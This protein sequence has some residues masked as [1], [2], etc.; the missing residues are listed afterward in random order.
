MIH[1]MTAFASVESTHDFGRLVWELRTVNHRYQESNLR[2]PEDFRPMEPAF[3]EQISA[4]VRRG[5]LDGN[6]KFKPS[7]GFAGSNLKLNVDLANSL[8]AMHED[9]SE[10]SG[11]QATA[12]AMEL[13][14]WPGVVEEQSGDVQPLRDAAVELLQQAMQSLSA[15]R[16]REGAKLQN[17]INERLDGIEQIISDVTGW[18]PEI[19]SQIREK[20]LARIDQLK[21]PLDEGRMEQEVAFLAQKLDVDEELD[22]L[23]MHV[24]ETRR[25]LTLEEPVGRQLDFLMQEFNREANTL[26]SKSADNR[27]SKAGV[28]LKVLIEQMREQVQNVE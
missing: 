4:F 28:E 7:G 17:V 6:L 3:R 14:R 11:E 26:S 24:G 8:L 22:R 15:M 21:Q 23:K 20:M 1:S 10:L 27:T 16:E 9:L 2:L 19:R 25:V 5:K 12:N 13:L 18:L